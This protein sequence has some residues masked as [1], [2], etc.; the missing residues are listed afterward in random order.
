MDICA[1]GTLSAGS[2]SVNFT[3]NHPESCTI[4]SCNMPGWP[5]TPPVIPHGGGTVH[6]TQ[7]APRGTYNY[8]PD[9][10]HKRTGPQIKVQ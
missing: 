10:C 8:T 2:T 3:N 5:T 7:P 1:G 4:T 9:C 6:L